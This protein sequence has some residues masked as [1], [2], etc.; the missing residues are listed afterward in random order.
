MKTRGIE[1]PEALL[2][3]I[4]VTF[5][6]CSPDVM[7][8][9]RFVLVLKLSLLRLNCCSGFIYFVDIFRRNMVPLKYCVVPIKITFG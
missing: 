6:L 3:H 8:L 2:E 4:K 7:T 1:L 9:S 5:L